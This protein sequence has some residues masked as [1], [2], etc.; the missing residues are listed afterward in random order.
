[1]KFQLNG[2]Q[3]DSFSANVKLITSQGNK[4]KQEKSKDLIPTP[5]FIRFT[6]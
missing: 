5:D 1:M 2:R 3:M 6:T 4:G